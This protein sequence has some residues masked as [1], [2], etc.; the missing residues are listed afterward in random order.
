MC[1]YVCRE[2]MP[3]LVEWLRDEAL[4]RGAHIPQAIV[5][6]RLAVVAPAC[7]GCEIAFFRRMFFF[8]LLT[9][10]FGRL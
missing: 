10:F 3:Q 6:A 1:V 8:S 2:Q 4:T 5:R 7:G 9:F